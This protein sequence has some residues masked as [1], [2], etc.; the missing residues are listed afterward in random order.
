MK[1]QVV[2]GPSD[3]YHSVVQPLLTATVT[4]EHETTY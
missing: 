4:A 3:N 1:K 2:T